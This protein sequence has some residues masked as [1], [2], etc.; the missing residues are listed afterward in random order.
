MPSYDSAAK[1]A[2]EIINC[3]TQFESLFEG[4]QKSDDFERELNKIKAYYRRAFNKTSSECAGQEIVDEYRHLFLTLQ[5]VKSGNITADEAMSS[6]EDLGDCRTLD[7]L[8]SNIFKMCELLFWAAAAAACYVACISVGIP[9]IACNPILGFAISVSTAVLCISTMERCLNCFAEFKSFDPVEA[10]ATREQNAVR[11]FAPA[12]LV[13]KEE[14][15]IIEEEESSSLS[16][17]Q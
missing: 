16:S 17:S 12:V 5:Q 3:E 13:Q 1:L 4:L 7:V 11:F 9:A 8:L 14:E 15:I 6:V 10:E 2:D